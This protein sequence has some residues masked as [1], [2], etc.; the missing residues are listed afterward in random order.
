MLLDV[1]KEPRS[2]VW[3]LEYEIF[4]TEL[5]F[6]FCLSELEFYIDQNTRVLKL[7]ETRN[8]ETEI[9]NG[10]VFHCLVRNAAAPFAYLI[11]PGSI[12]DPLISYCG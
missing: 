11:S 1:S 2:Y 3:Q 10:N 6:A 5:S 7:L 9:S 12:R 4:Y 8:V